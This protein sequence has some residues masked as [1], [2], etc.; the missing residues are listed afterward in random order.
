MRGMRQVRAGA[1]LFLFCGPA[2]AQQVVD[3]SA[4]V[5][6]VQPAVVTLRTFDGA[7][8]QLGLASGFVVDGGRVVTNAHV[9]EGAARVEVFD[10]SD[11]K[12]DAVDHAEVLNAG[13]D[14][15]VLPPVEGAR[16]ALA[17]AP[18]KPEVGEA[19]LAI[20]SPR[21]LTHT[22]SD[23]L[24]SA[25]REMDGRRWI[26]ISAPLSEGSS[27][28]PVLN[29]R[30]EVVGV[31]V[32]VLAEGQNL[33]FAI[34]ADEVRA[35]LAAPRGRIAFHPALPAA[36]HARVPDVRAGETVAGTLEPSDPRLPNG[37]YLDT[38]RFTGKAGEVVTITVRS[39]EFD[40]FLVVG[41]PDDHGR[42]LAHDDDGAG[43]LDA[44]LTLT[45]P[46]DGAYP[47][48]VASIGPNPT[49]RYT[50]SVRRAAAG[51]AAFR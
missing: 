10:A 51:A 24:V 20:G 42:A 1:A 8:R 49:G 37:A 5:R 18:G 26:Q 14:L 6:R 50:V 38:Y 12:L 47:V 32:A 35:V 43:N 28:G 19:I 17:L 23:G 30:G 9:V 46:R 34:P 13:A 44:E 40:A 25:V 4:V 29:A 15:A 22:V 31:S 41:D 16:T 36:S 27:G 11:R 3:F 7:G 33:N 39:S 21:G 45:L 2:A 48:A